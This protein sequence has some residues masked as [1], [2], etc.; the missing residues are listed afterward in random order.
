MEV[1]V[2]PKIITSSH[3]SEGGRGECGGNIR[4]A[5]PYGGW[6]TETTLLL[7]GGRSR[8]RLTKGNRLER[9]LS[10]KKKRR[11]PALGMG[12]RVSDLRGRGF[13]RKERDYL[14]KKGEGKT[15]RE[16]RPPPSPIRVGP[17][18][19]GLLPTVLRVSGIEGPDQWVATGTWPFPRKLENVR[20]RFAMKLNRSISDRRGGTY[21]KKRKWNF[22]C[23]GKFFPYEAAV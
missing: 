16:K 21:D 23:L 2:C 7:C 8:K 18:T 9:G 15:A 14:R 12:R 20:K 13:N 5:L 3:D 11:P 6:T 22:T 17:F 10:M 4:E 1:P 19:K